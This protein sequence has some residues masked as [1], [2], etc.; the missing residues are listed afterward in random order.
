MLFGESNRPCLEFTLFDLGSY[1]WSTSQKRRVNIWN[2]MWILW[3]W[4]GG[5]HPGCRRESTSAPSARTSASRRTTWPSISSPSILTIIQVTRAATSSG[6]V[7]PYGALFYTGLPSA[8]LSGGI[9]LFSSGLSEGFGLMTVGSIKTWLIFYKNV[10]TD[11]VPY[12]SELMAFFQGKCTFK[13]WETGE[14][15]LTF[16]FFLVKNVCCIFILS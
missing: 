7:G 12:L 9:N 4:G 13:Q 3:W 15:N 5:G 1:S 11:T 16:Q 10:F 8:S 14:K 2:Q 6:V